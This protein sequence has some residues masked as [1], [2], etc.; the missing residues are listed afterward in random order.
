MATMRFFR[1]ARRWGLLRGTPRALWPQRAVS[2]SPGTPIRAL[3]HPAR[4]QAGSRACAQARRALGSD[5]WRS[6]RRRGGTE[7]IAP[8]HDPPAHLTR[9]GC[10][11]GKC[12]RGL[13]R[14][15]ARRRR[16]IV[17]V[18]SS[19]VSPSSID[20]PSVMTVASRGFTSARC[21]GERPSRSRG[22]LGVPSIVVSPSVRVSRHPASLSAMCA[23]NRMRESRVYGVD[24][25]RASRRCARRSFRLRG[26]A[27]AFVICVCASR[28]GPAASSS[29][30][31][32][33]RRH[34]SHFKSSIQTA[35]SS[36]LRGTLSVLGFVE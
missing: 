25:W 7:A 31:R 26:L 28:A 21:R 4:S 3:P 1:L 13:F 29:H 8:P 36:G 20:P 27:I 17:V 2:P 10:P 35:S 18:G 24:D 34:T 22:H 30:L 14:A 16:P 33:R 19:H 32:G 12:S 9:A 23:L 5:H 11:W 6:A 15:A